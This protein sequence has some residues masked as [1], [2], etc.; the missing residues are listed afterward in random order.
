VFTKVDEA[1]RHHVN[2]E[3][4]AEAKKHALSEQK[5]R[6]ERVFK[7]MLVRV[8]LLL[9]HRCFPQQMERKRTQAPLSHFKPPHAISGFLFSLLRGHEITSREKRARL[10]SAKE[11]GRIYFRKAATL[12]YSFL[13]SLLFPLSSEKNGILVAFTR[14]SPTRAH[15]LGKLAFVSCGFV[16]V[17]IPAHPPAHCPFVNPQ[18]RLGSYGLA[19]IRV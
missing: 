1:C 9:F 16:L 17:R 8:C 12:V 18:R 13:S 10:L 3:F 14:G 2:V 11:K 15:P 19:S 6:F 7:F 5:Y 4:E